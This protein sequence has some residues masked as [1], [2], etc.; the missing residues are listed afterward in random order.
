MCEIRLAGPSDVPAIMKYINA[1]A[2]YEKA[3][4]E[5]Q[6]TE[7]HLSKSLFCE[8]PAVFAHVAID[9]EDADR[10]I[11]GI[12][13]WFLNYSTWTGT[14]GIYLEDLYVDEAN[15][16][17]GFGLSLLSELAK[18]CIAKGY[19]RLQWSCLDWNE[20]SI[21][22]YKSLGAEVLDEWTGYRMNWGPAMEAL[23]KMK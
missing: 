7:E 13:V 1:L 21:K 15:R 5:V 23:A 3:L 16:N 6:C 14:H 8:N 17:R 2:I 20:P 10:P 18:V 19:R 11:V 9:T 4:H 22:F 12:A